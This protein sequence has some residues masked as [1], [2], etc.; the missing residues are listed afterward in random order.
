MPFLR[1]WGRI[2]RDLARHGLGRLT[3]PQKNV[4]PS[5]E[6]N[7]VSPFGLGLMFFAR[8]VSKKLMP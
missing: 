7:P 2:F 1:V 3:P 4:A 8:L 5:N 6:M